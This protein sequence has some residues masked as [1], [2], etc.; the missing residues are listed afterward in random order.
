MKLFYDI[1]K[2]KRFNRDE[3]VLNEQ[4]EKVLAYDNDKVM[5]LLEQSFKIFEPLKCQISTNFVLPKSSYTQHEH[6]NFDFKHGVIELLT[7]PRFY[8]GL[9]FGFG[10]LDHKPVLSK[11]YAYDESYLKRLQNLAN[12]LN[13]MSIPYTVNKDCT[14]NVKYSF[15]T[16]E[17][18]IVYSLNVKLFP[19][20]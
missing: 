9:Y 18:N 11:T 14:V 19:Q 4:G 16:E 5:E 13:D 7:N 6:T 15:S 12:G 1:N 10:T 3:E 17:G 20:A 8:N 2:V